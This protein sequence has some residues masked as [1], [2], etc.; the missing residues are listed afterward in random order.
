M[1]IRTSKKDP[2]SS[3]S[4]HSSSPGNLT[5]FILSAASLSYHRGQTSTVKS[6]HKTEIKYNKPAAVK[7]HWATRHWSDTFVE[8]R[9]PEICATQLLLGAQNERSCE[10]FGQRVRGKHGC[11]SIDQS[12]YTADWIP[13]CRPRYWLLV[14]GQRR[15]AGAARRAEAPIKW[16]NINTQIRTGGRKGEP[17][18]FTVEG[19]FCENI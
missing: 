5:S 7:G 19:K 2:S 6:Y 18:P 10:K 8:P 12:N 11:N 4:P 15:A 9:Q 1:K 17:P 16:K 3:R 13:L 14:T